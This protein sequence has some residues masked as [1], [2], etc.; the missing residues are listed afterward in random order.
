MTETYNYFF[1]K[2]PLPCENEKN[3]IFLTFR[4]WTF[5]VPS[6][7]SFYFTFLASFILYYI[8]KA[9]CFFRMSLFNQKKSILEMCNTGLKTKKILVI[10]Q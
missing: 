1:E 3:T 6:D 5:I 4:L 7:S 2:N 9:N 10:D 8:L